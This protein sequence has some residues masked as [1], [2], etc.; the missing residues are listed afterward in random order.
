[1]RRVNVATKIFKKA[2]REITSMLVDLA[3]FDDAILGTCQCRGCG[4]LYDR[5]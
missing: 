2:H 5:Y 4:T 1:M 3:H